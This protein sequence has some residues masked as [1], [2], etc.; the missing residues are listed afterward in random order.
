[1]DVMTATRPGE[2][3]EH[4]DKGRG[5]NAGSERS[6]GEAQATAAK[7]A[8]REKKAEGAKK[9]A[10]KP[11]ANRANRKA[12]VIA[13]AMNCSFSTTPSAR[14]YCPVKCGGDPER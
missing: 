10:S 4:Q 7:K 6:R 14:S 3:D 12:E 1:M 11:I 9:P 13:R 2:T 5:E 8:N